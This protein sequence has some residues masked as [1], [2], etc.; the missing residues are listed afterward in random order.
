MP[1]LRSE[2]KHLTRGTVIHSD[3]TNETYIVT[4]NYGSHVTAVK[5]VDVT[6]P[7][8]WSLT[9]HDETAE[10]LLAHDYAMLDQW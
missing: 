9:Q 3:I 6:N 8:E 4:G 1:M 2:L 7:S 10:E 5:T